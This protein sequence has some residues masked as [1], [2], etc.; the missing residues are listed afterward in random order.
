MYKKLFWTFFVVV[1]ALFFESFESFVEAFEALK[2]LLL[3]PYRACKIA[4][5][6]CPTYDKVNNVTRR[7]MKCY[8]I[9]RRTQQPWGIGYWTHKSYILTK[10]PAAYK[11]FDKFNSSVR[12]WRHRSVNGGVGSWTHKSCIL[13]NTPA[14]HKSFD[15]SSSFKL[16]AKLYTH[17]CTFYNFIELEKVGKTALTIISRHSISPLE[18]WIGI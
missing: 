17:F 4:L 10:S 6:L 15:V 1:V 2:A 3:L 14:A 9:C 7:S 11:Y 12:N 18:Y 16:C 13:T 5:G 8:Y